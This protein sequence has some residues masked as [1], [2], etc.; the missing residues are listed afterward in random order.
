MMKTAFGAIVNLLAV[1][2]TSAAASDGSFRVP[3]VLP[4]SVVMVR[5]DLATRLAIPPASIE[6][7]RV[8]ESVWPD[9]CLGLP[10][11]ELCAPGKT[12]GY[13]VDLRALGQNYHYHTD[14]IETFRYA[15]PGDAPRRP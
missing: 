15:G 10:A 5:Q 13:R 9:T 8:E 7:T 6:V 12:A 1:L 3:T 2:A 4:Q 14:R 11:P